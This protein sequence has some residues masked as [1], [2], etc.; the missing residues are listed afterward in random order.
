MGAGLYCLPG[1]VLFAQHSP[2]LSKSGPG[3][4]ETRGKTLEPQDMSPR[5]VLRP[6]WVCQDSFLGQGGFSL[7]QHLGRYHSAECEPIHTGWV[8][9]EATERTGPPP[10]NS[11]SRGATKTSQPQ[12]RKSQVRRISQI[13]DS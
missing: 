10:S 8:F 5:E 1:H 13:G 7:L 4:V 9:V 11:L 2:S 3:T 6:H 12:A